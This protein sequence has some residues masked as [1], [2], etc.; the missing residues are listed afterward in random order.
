MKPRTMLLPGLLC[1]TV[2]STHA[3]EIASQPTFAVF[4]ALANSSHDVLLSKQ[5]P[6]FNI[7]LQ[8]ISQ[9]SQTIFEYQNSWGFYSLTLEITGL[10]GKTLD[11]PIVIK[12]PGLGWGG[13][14]PSTSTLKPK[15]LVV[16]EFWLRLPEKGVTEANAK[17]DD[18]FPLFGES[19]RR[20]V[21][22]RAVFSVLPKDKNANQ[23]HTVWTGRIV[24]PDA[25]YTVY[26]DR[27]P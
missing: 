26:R 14:G 1:L 18:Q 23:N 17:N 7:I 13:N 9:K 22:M 4:I 19:S 16:R 2:C 24:S 20:E 3:D 27:L 10:D 8:N 6:H 12:Q 11:K 21:T 25:T 5:F 15:A